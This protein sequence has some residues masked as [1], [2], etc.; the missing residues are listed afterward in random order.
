MGW[1]GNDLGN[2]SLGIM[3][4]FAV[5]FLLIFEYSLLFNMD[6]GKQ[7][8]CLCFEFVD[9]LKVTDL[10]NGSRKEGTG[11]Y[12]DMLESLYYFFSPIFCLLVS[13]L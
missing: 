6:N 10:G 9:G 12:V 1:W 11:D 7:C 13:V 4:L 2:F 5:F 8:Y 3:T